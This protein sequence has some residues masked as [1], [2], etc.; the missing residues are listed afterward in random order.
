[1]A[2]T[3]VVQTHDAILP[4]V[5]NGVTCAAVNLGDNTET[6]NLALARVFEKTNLYLAAM[7]LRTDC[8][9]PNP[10]TIGFVKDFNNMY[11]R[12]CQMIDA[13]TKP[14]TMERLESA[15]VTNERRVFQRFPVRYFDV[16][17]DYCK[18]YIELCLQGL[19]NLA[20]LSENTWSNDWS[21]VTAK[22]MKKLFR[23]A[24]RLMCVEL[25][26][27]SPSDSAKV[28]DDKAP[29]FLSQEQFDTYNISARIPSVEWIAQPAIGSI[30]TE[31]EMRIG[32]TPRVPVA[33]GV[34][35]NDPN[36]PARK[37]EAVVQAA[38]HI[39]T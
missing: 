32:L 3:L 25:F 24:Y 30:P 17:N 15:H 29:Y 6:N 38:P 10:P 14:D 18:R 37:D 28:F 1:M 34:P 19:S 35:E 7:S 13:G 22:E 33:P 5:Y 11:V 4:Y 36:S 2:D 39:V 21:E 9:L 16:K 20:Q 8:F 12:F 23:E 31:D 26:G 27:V